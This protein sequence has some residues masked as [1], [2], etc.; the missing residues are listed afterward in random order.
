MA[1]T[2]T[3]VCPECEK[4]LKASPQVIG[5]KIRCKSCGHTFAAQAPQGKA[6]KSARKADDDDEPAG[7]Y[8]VTSEYLGPRCPDCANAMEEGDI[9][10]LHCGYNTMTRQK[11]RARKI[12]E[13]TGF[14]IFLWLLPGI[15]CALVVIALITAD[16]LYVFLV[17][18]KKI[19]DEWYGFLGSKGVKMWT[20][21]VVIFFVFLAG[22]FAVKR[23]IINNYPPEVEEK[24]V[25]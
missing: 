5:K 3:I 1:S 16:L 9:V 20:S 24:W 15:L 6:G 4:S 25:K 2:I 19:E 7:A 10:C 8:G 22:S 23:L 17:D 11:S 18:Y 12:R 21:I 13:I 14:D